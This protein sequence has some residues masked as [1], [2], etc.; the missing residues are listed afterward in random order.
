MKIKIDIVKIFKKNTAIIIPTAIAVVAL[1]LFVPT[2]MMRGKINV[3]L[4]E[5]VKLGR[6]VD[7]A[8]K[9][10]V[11]GKQCEVAK[12]YQDMHQADANEIDI[13]AQQTSQ[14]ELLSYKIFPEPNE[15]SV[16][17][18]N[19]FKKT[20]IAAFAKLMKDMNALDAPT[21]NEIRKQAGAINIASGSGY[22][23]D[24]SRAEKGDERIVE[25]ICQRRSDEIPVYA[26]PK[27]FSGYGF[28]DKWEYSGTEDALRGCWY[29]QLAYWIHQDIVDTINSMNSGS[30]SVANSSVKR[31]LE[32]RFT[33][34]N[35]KDNAF[36]LP[37][38][39]TNTGGDIIQPWT[40]RKC[41]DKIDV[42]HFSLTVI[43]KADDVL[44][45]MAELCSEKEHY[46][47]GYKGNQEPKKYKHNQITILRSDIEPINRNSPEQKRYY[48]GQ[49]AV[50]LLNL[51]CEYVFERQGY[52][53]IKPKVVQGNMGAS[54]GIGAAVQ[55]QSQQ[56][57]QAP[58]PSGQGKMGI[59]E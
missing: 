56:Q 2:I 51:I 55:Q 38:Y 25:L 20:Y 42:I 1:L 43:V 50:V 16:Q 15:T 13:L 22:E 14:R 3:R 23:Q 30:T 21:D 33:G 28:W 24:N 46:F 9:T 59:G 18:F 31:L 4:Q 36:E 53:A 47:A 6:E 34:E 27:V 11:S 39:V 12:K 35:N 32:M 52:D 54:S 57:Q 7:S 19:E 29:C 17:I 49:K 10:T 45:F 41:N 5:S 26:N 37:A 48:Y 58:P 44:K 40:T 8:L